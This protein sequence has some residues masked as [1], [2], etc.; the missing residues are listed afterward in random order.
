MAQIGQGCRRGNKAA[1]QGHS[2]AVAQQKLGTIRCCARN[3][4]VGRVA[5]AVGYAHIAAMVNQHLAIPLCLGFPG[6]PVFRGIE[7]GANLIAIT[8]LHTPFRTDDERHSHTI[9]GG[10]HGNFTGRRRVFWIVRQEGG[11]K[12]LFLKVRIGQHVLQLVGGQV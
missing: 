2:N 1:T 6:L 4:A 8:V 5:R 12:F 3:V 10:G 9:V 7:Q 11:R